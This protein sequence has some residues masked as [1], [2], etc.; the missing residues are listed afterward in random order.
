MNYGHVFLTTKNWFPGDIVVFVTS[1]W[2]HHQ[3]QRC[4]L[5]TG[6]TDCRLRRSHNPT[7]MALRQ[8][9]GFRLSAGWTTAGIKDG[10][11][12][13]ALLSP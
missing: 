11:L 10:A 13:A 6:F 7:A 1:L 9:G 4:H 8:T 3:D 2:Y 12:L 5:A